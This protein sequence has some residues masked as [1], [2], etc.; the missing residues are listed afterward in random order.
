MMEIDV[1]F[2]IGKEA[3]PL[4]KPPFRAYFTWTREGRLIK[5]E[6]FS[7]QELQAEIASGQRDGRE[8][9]LFNKALNQLA[10]LGG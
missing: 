6:D 8:L 5:A 7:Q 2:H 3:S 10:H 4:D 1:G 9:K